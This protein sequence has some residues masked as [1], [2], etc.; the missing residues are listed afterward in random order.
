MSPAE[1]GLAKERQ[2]GPVG[3]KEVEIRWSLRIVEGRRRE[4]R[5]L[6][7]AEA[8]AH[9]RLGEGRACLRVAHGSKFF[10]FE[11]ESNRRTSFFPRTLIKHSKGGGTRIRFRNADVVD[12]PDQHNPMIVTVVL[13]CN[14]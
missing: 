13:L 9:R 7:A 8:G 2:V 5:P 10:N 4:C 3:R 11:I 14:K 1:A 6:P 12:C